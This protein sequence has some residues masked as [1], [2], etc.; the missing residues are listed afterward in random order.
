MKLLSF[1]TSKGLSYGV[2]TE[3]GIVDV[4]ATAEAAG[5][6]VSQNIQELISKG[7]AGRRELEAVLSATAAIVQ[8][9]EFQYAPA[10][11]NPGKIICVGANYKAHAEEANMTAPE[12]PI[13]FAKFANSLAAHEEEV[14]LPEFVDQ[15][16]YEVELVAVIGEQ[17]HQ[18]TQEQA[19]AKV[20]GYATGND[21]SARK[22]QFRSNQW[23][24]GKA[25][26]G[27]APIGPYL[28]TA[29]EVADP[30]N[31]TLSCWVNG[32]LRQH[33]NTKD[34]IFPIAEIISD[35]SQIMTLEPGDVIYTG[36]PE[37]VILGMEEPVW[38][39]PGDEIAC[40]VEG[41]GRLENRLIAVKS[42]EEKEQAVSL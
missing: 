22:Q 31:L 9:G 23:M 16:D 2:K 28:V 27:F 26:D 17:T 41:L 15:G 11:Q 32:E 37:G 5:L 39:K 25:I 4:K 35:L 3:Q 24:F 8:E 40:E 38:L 18:V 7:E 33:A 29:E 10:V 14:V 13:Y 1:T 19:L 21:L 20:Y 12:Y 34:M 30:Q 42:R 36:T 6:P